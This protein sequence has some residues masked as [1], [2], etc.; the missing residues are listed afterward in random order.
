MSNSRW[1]SIVSCWFQKVLPADDTSIKL[2]LTTSPPWTCSPSPMFSYKM[3]AQRWPLQRCVLSPTICYPLRPF[4]H[5]QEL[6]RTAAAIH[7][8][9][10]HY[11]A[12]PLKIVAGKLPH[13]WVHS[14]WPRDG[15]YIRSRAS[16]S[17]GRAAPPCS[18]LVHGRQ[19]IRSLVMLWARLTKQ[20]RLG[21]RVF[22]CADRRSNACGP[23]QP[24]WSHTWNEAFNGAGSWGEPNTVERKRN[25]VPLVVGWCCAIE[26]HP[27]WGAS[28]WISFY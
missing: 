20:R 4:H 16:T 19:S 13:L 26:Y 28:S 10:S 15:N 3:V 1:Y 23:T 18:Y 27:W 7:R 21:I 8:W 12:H 5:K 25:W 22:N 9:F 2:W 6:Y 14:P 11:L 17:E 24:F